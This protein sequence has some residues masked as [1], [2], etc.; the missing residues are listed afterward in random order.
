L[1][2]VAGL[3]GGRVACAPIG[4][5][6]AAVPV[7]QTRIDQIELRLLARRALTDDEGAFL[8]AVIHR[9]LGHPFPIDIGYIDAIPRT[10]SG[11]HEDFRCE[12]P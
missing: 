11:K 5:C 10:E 4:A 1:Q 2:Q 12:V 8:R 6:R 7:V 9:N 3:T